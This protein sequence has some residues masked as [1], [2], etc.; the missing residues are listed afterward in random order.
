MC[1]THAISVCIFTETV[2]G[3][4]RQQHTSDTGSTGTY[5][6][7]VQYVQHGYVFGHVISWCAVSG[8]VLIM[9]CVVFLHSTA[10]SRL[11]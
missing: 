7:C 8:G 5:Y 2:Y 6:P 3:G 11:T 9:Y 4:I 10:A 1:V